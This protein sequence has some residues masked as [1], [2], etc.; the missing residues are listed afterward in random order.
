[1]N[2]TLKL[3][4]T[5]TVLS[6]ALVAQ[7]VVTFDWVIVGN[8]GNAADPETGYGSV[9]HAFRISKYEVTN[10]QYVEFLNATDPAGSQGHLFDFSQLPEYERGGIQFDNQAA[11]GLK[12]DAI[13]GRENMPV[14]WISAPRAQMF[15]NWLENGQ[16]SGDYVTGTYDLTANSD[17]TR[18]S[19]ATFFLPNNDEWYKAAYHQNDGV[20]ANYWDY[21]MSSDD[22]PYSDDPDS[23]NTPDSSNTANFFKDDSN[24]NGFD[25]GYA[26]TGQPLLDANEYYLSEVG[27]YGTAMSPYGTFD[28]GGNAAEVTEPFPGPPGLN[29]FIL[30]G[31]SFSSGSNGLNAA[32]RVLARDGSYAARYGFRVASRIP[33]PSTLLLGALAGLGLLLRSLVFR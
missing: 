4:T 11:N 7:A 16:G 30:R 27:A 21:P 20:T 14:L 26:V 18:K 19:T 3:L 17:G 22:I 32:T 5:L 13:A 8:A 15:V 28:Q 12:Y 6:H 10:T 33:E 29:I 31:G 9:D 2:N 24:A 25:D 1:M 23:V